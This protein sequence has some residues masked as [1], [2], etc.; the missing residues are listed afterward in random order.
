MTV[1]TRAC[2]CKFGKNN[3]SPQ[4]VR[5]AQLPLPAVRAGAGGDL[6]R[7]RRRVRGHQRHRLQ[8]NPLGH[9]HKG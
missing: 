7:Q 3:A 8:E 5:T 4:F 1:K 6:G 2:M 9:L